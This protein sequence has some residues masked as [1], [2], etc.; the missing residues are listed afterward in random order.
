MNSDIDNLLLKLSLISISDVNVKTVNEST[1]AMAPP[2]ITDEQ[3]KSFC[4][5]IP[6]FSPEQNDTLSSFIITVDDIIKL[7]ES[8]T[9]AM[10]SNV[11]V[12]LLNLHIVSKLRDT[13]H[14][15]ITSNNFHDFIPDSFTT[16]KNIRKALLEQFGQTKSEDTLFNELQNEKQKFNEHYREFHLR[17]NAK[18]N[19]LMKHVRLTH[20]DERKIQ[21]LKEIYSNEALK[22][23]ISGLQSPYRET[24]YYTNP[25]TLHECL[26]QCERYSNLMSRTPG[27][28][29]PQDNPRNFNGF[30]NSNNNNNRFRPNFRQNN[31]NS[32]Y[33]P[34]NI[35][36]G[37]NNNNNTRNFVP[38]QL[39]QPQ[40]NAIQQIRNNQ[41]W[42]PMS[43][44]T[45]S[46][47]QNTRQNFHNLE[48]DSS[49][50]S[51]YSDNYQNQPIETN[52]NYRD[53]ISEID[54]QEFLAWKN[55]KKEHSENFPRQASPN[56]PI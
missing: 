17:I 4:Q 37:N 1:T 33:N 51:S 27:R 47:R 24:V 13:A 3:L 7:F 11:Q 32:S 16:W 53:N 22:T 54:Y 52:Q 5:T 50:E 30:N 14:T 41:H 40:H 21:T 15:Y 25:R 26:E 10:C 42:E 39:S 56:N 44:R 38:R 43:A 48:L 45:T 35:R 49:Y 28:S 12:H 20:N 2:V 6:Y 9:F 34:N 8:G 46:N 19:T 55:Q 31:Y 23:F 36:L 18:F 29:N